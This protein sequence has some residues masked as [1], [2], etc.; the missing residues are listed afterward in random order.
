MISIPSSKKQFSQPNNSD[1]F[2]NIYYTRNVNFD[3]QGY[4]KLSNRSV[5]LKSSAGDSNFGI[6]PSFGRISAGEFF[7]PTSGNPY[8]AQISSANITVSPDANPMVP[9]GLGFTTGGRWWNDRWFI[10]TGTNV[11]YRDTSGNPWTKINIPS[12]AQ[13]QGNWNASTN[14]PNL[15]SG[16]GTPG[17]FYTV[18]VAGQTNLDGNYPW[19]VGDIAYFSGQLGK[20]LNINL[21]STLTSGNIHCMDVFRSR[22]TLCVADGN[23][24]H[25]FDTSYAQQQATNLI[26][27]SDFQIC[28]M[29][30]SGE[31]LGI[32]TRLSSAVSGKN[33]ESQ[34]YVWDGTADSVNSGTPIGADMA[35]AIVAYKSSWVILT[36][37]GQLLYYTGASAYSVGGFKV[38]ATF[39][40]YFKNQVWG[41]FLN[42]LAYG[43]AIVVNGDYIYINIP[44]TLN[45]YGLPS[46]T[47]SPQ[48][49]S[50]IWCYDPSIGL[51]HRNS[52]SISQANIG[53]IQQS[54]IDIGTSQVTVY[55]GAVVPVTGNPV[56]YVNDQ[57]SAIGGLSLYTT[58]YVIQISTTVFQL[59]TTRANALAGIFIPLISQGASIH[60][61]LFVNVLDY[62]TSGSSRVGGIGLQ[63]ISNQVLQQYLYSSFLLPVNSSAEM[64]CLCMDIPFFPSRGYVVTSKLTSSAVED[65]YEKVFIKF[66]NMADDDQIILK[67]KLED[68]QGL[69]FATK[70]QS[71]T[72]LTNTTFTTSSDLSVAYS[73]LQLAS[74]VLEAEIIN[75]AGSG[76]GSTVI[77]ITLAAGVYTVVLKD[78]LE[79]ITVGN[80]CDVCLE[81]WKQFGQVS[82]T[83]VNGYKELPIGIPSKQ[84]S[85]KAIMSGVSNRM[86]IES[87]QIINSI[88]RGA[89]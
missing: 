68:V 37:T 46:Q 64:P 45:S 66:S 77:S 54:G 49:Q 38:L 26:L 30:Y 36:R 5:L 55:T 6:V 73:Y 21:S 9:Q 34:F 42:Q 31:N 51:Y 69:P 82:T 24:V 74:K 71:C 59:A 20:W 57:G 58:Y 67:Q 7:I 32:I 47:S 81:N 18:N 27:Q 17:F 52:P 29:A 2:G 88:H 23:I 76:Q 1:L 72:W 79:G 44:G 70:G 65:Q 39:P 33:I 53:V 60:N 84:V 22:N 19:N 28:G 85:I 14:T 15:Q 87:L 13:D 48:F 35:V 89:E 78:S 40:F 86:R 43:D 80:L 83:D 11:W 16:V 8:I 61:F 12:D 75:G 25:Q 10:T 62:G 63:G 56:R 41:D 4:V 50:G 3:E